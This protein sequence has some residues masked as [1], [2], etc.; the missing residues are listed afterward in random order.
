MPE[1]FSL[2]EAIE[3]RLKLSDSKG[4]GYQEDGDRT[5]FSKISL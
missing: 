4:S 5:H 2:A 3:E 1:L